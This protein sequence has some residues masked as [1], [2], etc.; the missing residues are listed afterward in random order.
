MSGEIT[1]LPKLRPGDP[2]P[3]KSRFFTAFFTLC[4]LHHVLQ[5]CFLDQPAMV[6]F[7]NPPIKE[8]WLAANSHNSIPA[9]SAQPRIVLAGDTA[10]LQNAKKEYNRNLSTTNANDATVRRAVFAALGPDYSAELFGENQAFVTL[11]EMMEKF[12]EHLAAT[13]AD[14]MELLSKL[15]ITNL[16]KSLLSALTQLRAA[17]ELL[18]SCNIPQSLAQQLSTL[19]IYLSQ[20]SHVACL[21]AYDQTTLPDARTFSGLATFATQWYNQYSMGPDAHSLHL[22]AQS[23]SAMAA[24]SAPAA[25]ASAY[26][27]S[28]LKDDKIALLEREIAKLKSANGR[29]R[30]RDRGDNRREDRRDNR[31]GRGRSASRASSPAEPLWCSTHHWCAHI[32]RNCLRPG[33]RGNVHD[34]NE[35]EPPAGFQG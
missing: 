19:T 5:R 29:G 33:C 13:P 21:Q 9:A 30:Q 15:S 32:S 27:A 10:A 2:F 16:P 7:R 4:V 20:P 11:M 25:P 26:A 3:Q 28:A 14:K 17:H 18:N 23:A 22:H 8:A 12:Q 35:T 31:G 1:I 24:A 6:A 34:N